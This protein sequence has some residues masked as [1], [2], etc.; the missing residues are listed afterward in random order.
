MTTNVP[1]ITFTSTGLILPAESDILAGTLSDFNDAFGGQLNI[2]SLETPQGQLASSEAA[3]IAEKNNQ[4]AYITAQF[5]PDQAEGIYQDAIAKIY[6][7]DRKQATPTSVQLLC[8]GAVGTV[9]PIGAKASDASG[10]I[11]QAVQ[12]G[13]IDVTGSVTLTF[14]N[15]ATG[16]TGCPAETVTAIYQSISGWDKV[17][18]PASGIPGSEVETQRDFEI[19]RRQSVLLNNVGTNT[20]IY[21]NVLNL[22]DVTDCYVIDNPFGI[23][24]AKGATGY[25]MFQHSIYVAVIGGNSNDIAS[26]IL[27]CKPPGSQYMGTTVIN[28]S[29]TSD[30]TTPPVYPV[31]FHRPA[32]T[33]IKF[34]VRI[35]NTGTLPSDIVNT[36]KNAIVS[37]M[38]GGDGRGRVRIADKIL[39]SRFYAPIVASSSG[40]MVLSVKIG[41]STATLDTVTMGI[42]QAP[43]TTAADITVTLV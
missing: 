33:T 16:S 22:P 39:A 34:D 17:T 43:I 42:D 27:R 28:V 5:N 18:N 19:R 29:D 7:L 14:S 24:I 9:I 6:F 30:Y 37:A 20:S 36:V 3:I 10:N 21:A 1:Q 35:V 11:Y 38:V 41:T 26:T 32:A 12:T 4:I 31:K 13:V 23:A 40:V 2:D 8:T 15:V 25:V